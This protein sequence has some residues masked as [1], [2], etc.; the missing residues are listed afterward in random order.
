[1]ER[2]IKILEDKRNS[3]I[4]S[5][6]DQVTVAKSQGFRDGL[7]YAIEVLKMQIDEDELAKEHQQEFEYQL[8]A[9]R[10]YEMD[11]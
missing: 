8:R 3:F 11:S 9:S 1:M 10:S 7:Q 2:V 5:L 6:K 4:G